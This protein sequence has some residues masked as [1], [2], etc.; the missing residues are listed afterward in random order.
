MFLGKFGNTFTR[1]VL[2]SRY[3]PPFNAQARAAI[4]RSARF[5]CAKGQATCSK[6]VHID[7]LRNQPRGWGFEM[8]T[9]VWLLIM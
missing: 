6:V 9:G 5:A 3:I 2:G 7:I 4:G 8:I 1:V